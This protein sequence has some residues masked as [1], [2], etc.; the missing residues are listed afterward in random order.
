MIPAQTFALGALRPLSNHVWQSTVFAA[1]AGLLTLSLRTNHPRTRYW[2]W[3]VASIKFL[4]P[5]SLLALAG[6][7]LG[8]LVVSP[9][10][11][12]L[13]LS[14][15][16]TITSP[17]L[18]TDFTSIPTPTRVASANAPSAMSTFLLTLWLSGCGAILVRWSVRWRRVHGELRKSVICSEGVACLATRRIERLMGLRRA[19]RLVSLQTSLEPGVFGILRPV[20]V[21]PT[22]ISERLGAA[23]L[24][25]I[26]AHELAHIRWRDNLTSASHMLVEAIFWF[27]PLVWWIGARLTL[28]RE[29]A[30]DEAVLELGN[31]R[32]VYTE[33]ILQTCFHYL[34][35]P[36]PFVSRV[37]GSNLKQRIERIM[38]DCSA[39]RLGLVKKMVLM[40]AGFAALTVPVTI[41]L[42]NAPRSRAQSMQSVAPA[43]PL[44]FDV[45]S[46]KP[47]AYP[48]GNL[49]T[50]QLDPGMLTIK[51]MSLKD[52]IQRAYGRGYALQLSRSDLVMGGPKWCDDDLYDI[53]AKPGGNP[54]GSGE[55]VSEMLKTLLA[56]RFKLAFH[57][58]SKVTSGYLLVVG[59][60]GP[61]MKER[62]PGDGGESRTGS[63][64]RIEGGFRVTRRDMS[65]TALADY[66]GFY[67]LDRPVLDNTGLAGTFDFDLTWTPD[68]TQFGGRYGGAP[69]GSNLPNLF[70]ALREQIGLS[71]E[72]GKV[73]IDVMVIDHAEKPSVN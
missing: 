23:Q 41:G 25:A 65:M 17:F 38:T 5:F 29:R 22:G 34:K 67:V 7:H 49:K 73:P 32:E 61:K 43:A 40:A 13:L 64:R 39:T 15:I 52:L 27:H 56:E 10:G 62:S 54:N 63:S 28:E 47:S 26:L 59:R 1:A 8:A 50:I 21:L 42:V 66:L 45:A 69:E 18:A 71:L 51:G 48:G 4:V 72:T 6:S 57:H 60:S 53:V 37:T 44:A 14:E 70:T 33:S 30:C 2:L 12:S 31:E 35:F 46:I 36:T 55:P 68:E 24:D 20:L 19:T 11:G 58:E 3:V 16:Q 9:T